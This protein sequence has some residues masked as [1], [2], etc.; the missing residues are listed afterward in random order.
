VEFLARLEAAHP[1][2]PRLHPNLAELYRQKG[3][4]HRENDL[5]SCTGTHQSPIR[6][7]VALTQV[8]RGVSLTIWEK[9]NGW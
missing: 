9:E 8:Q 5:L 7:I 4:P 1:S 2:M 3:D 6:S